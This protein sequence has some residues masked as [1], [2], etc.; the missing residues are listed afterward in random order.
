MSRHRRKAVVL[1]CATALV[2]SM[3]LLPRVPGGELTFFICAFAAGGV[4]YREF[5]PARPP[6]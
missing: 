1:L 5:A 6:H 4:L 2:A 3:A